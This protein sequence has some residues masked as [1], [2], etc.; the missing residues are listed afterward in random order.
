MISELMTA[1]MHS[2]EVLLRKGVERLGF[3]KL[4][5]MIWHTSVSGGSEAE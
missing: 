4:G 1:G 3:A 5:A 2:F